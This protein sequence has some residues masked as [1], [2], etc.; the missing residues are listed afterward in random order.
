MKK[1]S[2]SIVF[3]TVLVALILVVGPGAIIFPFIVLSPAIAVIASITFYYLYLFPSYGSSVLFILFIVGLFA[4]GGAA[5]SYAQERG[6]IFFCSDGGG[7][8][9]G[10]GG[11]FVTAP[12]AVSLAVIV[13][14]FLWFACVIAFKAFKPPH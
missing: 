13:Y 10:L 4:A 2:D 14:T 11:T 5:G 1:M 12:L 6:I 9:C 8:L 3:W 7:N